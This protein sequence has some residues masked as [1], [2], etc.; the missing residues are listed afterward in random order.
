MRSRW[1]IGTS[2]TQFYNVDVLVPQHVTVASS[3]M[4]GNGSCGLIVCT[5]GR[6]IRWGFNIGAGQSATMQFA[7]LV[8]SVNPPANGTVIQVPAIAFSNADNISAAIDVVVGTPGLSL[9]MRHLSTLVAP[10]GQLTSVLEYANPG[11]A[12]SAT[13][14]LVVPLP[15]GT[16][17]VSASG[18]GALSGGAVQWDVGALPPGGNGQRQLV[19]QVDALM[20]NASVVQVFAELRAA[21]GGGSLARTSEAAVVLNDI[22][23]ALALTATPDPVRPGEPVQYAITLANRTSGTQFYNVDVL[24]PQHV[25]VASSSMSGNGSCGLIVCTPGRTIRWGFNIGAG[26]SATMQFAALVDSV[27]PPANGTVIQVPAIA[28][29]NADNISAAIDV[30][31]GTPGLSLG[32]RHLST[33]VAPGGQLTSVLEYANPG[34]A[35]SATAQLVVPL[36][37][38][39]SLVSASGGG[40]LSGGAVQWDVGALPPGGNGQR[41]LVLQVDALMPNASVV[42]VFAEL[43][44]AVGGGSLARTSEAAVVLNDIR[45]ALALTA[46]P[47]PVRPGE[48]VQYAIT[49][50]NRTSGTQ[51]YNVD[52]LVPQHVTVASSSMSGNG[53]CGLIV[54]TPGRTIR[55]GFNIGAGQSATMQFA[56]LVDSVNP[57]ANGTVIQVPAIAFSNA[58]NISAAIDV[59]VGT[60]GLSLGMR[61]LSTLVAPGGQL[62]S[63]L[64]YANPGPATSATAQLVVPLPAGTS[65]VSA[66]GGGALSGGAVQWDVGALPPGGN[67]QRQLVLQVD[68]LMPNASVV[69]VFAE[70]RAAVGGGSLARTS[71]AAVVL[72]DIRAAL[73]LTATPDPVRP[74]EPVQYAITLANRTSGTQFYNVDVLV[75][76]HVTVA[77]SSMSGNGSCGLIVCT[78]GRTIRW[79]FNIGAGQSATM[80]FAAL[81]DSVNPPANGTVIQVPAIAFSNA[82]NISAAIDVVVSNV[83]RTPPLVPPSV[84]TLNAIPSALPTGGGGVTLTANCTGGDAPTSF[85]WSGGFA[86]GRVTSVNTLMGSITSTTAFVVVASNAGGSGSPVGVTVGVAFTPPEQTPAARTTLAAICPAAGSAV[87]TSTSTK[88]VVVAHGWNANAFDWVYEMALDV[89]DRIGATQVYSILNVDGTMRVCSGGGWD[90]WAVDWSTKA[91][92]LPLEAWFKANAVGRDM[93]SYF[94]QEYPQYRHFHLIAHSAGSNLINSAMLP[95]RSAGAT[96]QAT[97]LDAYDPGAFPP[98]PGLPYFGRHVSEYGKVANWVDNYVDT[99]PLGINFDGSGLLNLDRTDLHL[100]AG[101]NIDVTPFADGCNSLGFVDANV[102]R[103]GRP[104]RLYGTSV[105]D[106]YSDLPVDPIVQTGVVGFALSLEAGSSMNVLSAGKNQECRMRDDGSCGVLSTSAPG[107]WFYLT[108]AIAGTVADGAAGVVDYVKGTG[109]KWLNS[110]KL[111]V[112][113]LPLGASTKSIVSASATQR[114]AVASSE[115]ATDA[116]SWIALQVT[117]TQ[118]VSTL[119]FNWKFT[120]AGEGYVRV[121]VGSDLVREI[122]QRHVPL[123]SPVVEEVHIGGGTGALPAGTHR[124]AF[125]LDGFGVSPSGVE[126]TD[127]ELVQKQ[128][129]V[130]P[131]STNLLTV[132]ANGPGVVTSDPQG[133]LCG[134]DCSENYGVGTSVRVTATP[135]AGSIFAGW[136]G[137]CSG[138]G[139]CT[140]SMFAVA[141]VT[142]AFNFVGAGSANAN[143]WVQKAYVAYYGRPADSGGLA[144]LGRSA[145]ITK[146]ASLDRRSS[147]PSATPTNSTAATAG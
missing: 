77:S 103:H 11:P 114:L 26:Q 131:F 125:R 73:A 24:V 48:P 64:E 28:F 49:L 32:M 59:V 84:C 3:S 95:L 2:G 107:A 60:P 13:A 6:T 138:A 9:G 34:P 130:A 83:S 113:G 111:G 5:P 51:F 123:S 75:P 85:S 70:L 72:N 102:C 12:T 147:A 65:L 50:A 58:D 94:R 30:V 89:C 31:V 98:P 19:L 118:P 90:V 79:G 7:A 80:Q 62:T 10:G 88:A 99:R 39:T 133:I 121:F 146:A 14:Q 116:P 93:A 106:S 128:V 120:A 81:V 68:A 87:C 15:A 145:W 57:P 69:Q 100:S 104:Y 43:R 18:G 38:G 96:V 109:T 78:P 55:W 25:T 52:V 45:A 20:P 8:D 40:A 71:E 67:G 61:H 36:P 126:L 4:S 33:L 46:T 53:S 16:S 143:Q 74:G 21:V 86:N 108:G 135:S 122:D 137:G 139:S 129:S 105:S 56:A 29:S 47:D 134:S 76:Q 115:T 63:V 140:L 141:N 22:R 127:V 136:G 110:L 112:Q 41:Q 101:F 91:A 42:Q 37:A 27:N 142:A 92:G 124:I 97:F 66:S 82:D 44:A 117:T 54:C 132:V 1:P 17:L 119:R 144:L 23:A 35:T